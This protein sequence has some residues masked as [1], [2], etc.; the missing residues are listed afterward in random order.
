LGVLS[1]A[2]RCEPPG[3][4]SHGTSGVP[5]AI[6]CFC[7]IAG[8]GQAR[9]N[10]PICT[11]RTAVTPRQYPGF[12]DGIYCSAVD[13]PVLALWQAITQGC[14]KGRDEGEGT[15]HDQRQEISADSRT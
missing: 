13:Q 1:Q 3:D 6:S 9:H 11:W 14:F 4:A 7:R 2:D 10:S 15:Q 12:G 8:E 5:W